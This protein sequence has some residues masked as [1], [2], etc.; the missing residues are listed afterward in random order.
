M[1]AFLTRVVTILKDIRGGSSDAGVAPNGILGQNGSLERCGNNTVHCRNVQSHIVASTCDADAEKKFEGDGGKCKMHYEQIMREIEYSKGIIGRQ[2][3]RTFLDLIRFQAKERKV[4]L[5]S[6]YND[7]IPNAE[8]HPLNIRTKV[9]CG[10]NP[11]LDCMETW[12]S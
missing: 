12:K 10:D 4:E 7:L 8:T 3:P 6:F 9:L 5:K 1:A 11:L 2:K